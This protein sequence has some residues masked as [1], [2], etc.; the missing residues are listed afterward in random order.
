MK[1]LYMPPLNYVHPHRDIGDMNADLILAS[2]MKEIAN[3]FTKMTSTIVM[4]FYCL[5]FMFSYELK[6]FPMSYLSSM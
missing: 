3:Y 1:G 4:T 5:L 6:M 2:L